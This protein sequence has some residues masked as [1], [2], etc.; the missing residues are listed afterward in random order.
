VRVGVISDTHGLLRPEALEYLRGC[1]L[2]LH[3]GDIGN[4]EVLNELSA[5]APVVSVLGNNDHGAWAAS[6]PTVQTLVVLGH[7]LCIIHDLSELPAALER[8]SLSAVVFGHSHQPTSYREDGLLFFNPGSA[9]PRRFNLPI[10]AGELRITRS[11]VV[12]GIQEF[13]G[14]NP[15]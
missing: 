5:I 1:R 7:S 9:G 2:I 3:A 11:R 13:R 10:S 15:A 12:P 14:A 6:V 8:S 4:A